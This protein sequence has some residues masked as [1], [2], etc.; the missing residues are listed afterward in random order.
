MNS[1][2]ILADSNSNIELNEERGN[3]IVLNFFIG[4]IIIEKYYH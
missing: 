4:N 1:Q 3:E 2:I